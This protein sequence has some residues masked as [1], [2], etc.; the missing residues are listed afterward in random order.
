MTRLL[1]AVGIAAALL[2]VSSPVVET[3]RTDR[4]A[5]QLDRATD[6][7]EAA[8]ES[9]LAT[10]EAEAGARR[11]VTVAVPGA[12]LTAAGVERFGV[13]CR[14]RCGVRYTLEG[15]SSTVHQLP[16]PLATPDGP[17]T[18]SKPGSH[19]LTLGLVREEGRRVV[20]VRG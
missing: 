5:G 11:V 8:G 16:F 17:V 4:T 2:A 14:A 7:V 6:R 3:V 15:R 13:R 20:T 1:L 12:S 10:D 18:F 19:R 9:L